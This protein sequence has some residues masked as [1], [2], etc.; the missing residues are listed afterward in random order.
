MIKM[1]DARHSFDAKAAKVPYC[2]LTSTL[3]YNMSGTMIACGGSDL[4]LH[5][6]KV[7]SQ[8]F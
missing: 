2:K 5:L 4:G 3:K 7:T 8:G 6:F 1:W